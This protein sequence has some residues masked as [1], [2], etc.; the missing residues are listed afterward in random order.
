MLSRDE[1]LAIYRAG[2]E[3]MVALVEKLWATQVTLEQQVQVLAA[4]VAELEARL[5]Q[6]SHNSHQPPSSDGP[7]KR[8]RTRSLRQRSGKK[9]GGQA[10][11]PGVTRALVDDPDVVIPHMPTV[12]VGCGAA[13]ESVPEAGRERRQVIEIPKPRP[14]VTEHQAVQKAC[15]VC[16]TLTAGE[17]PPEVAQPVQ[18]GPRAKAAGVYLQTYQLLSYER[19]VEALGD[20]FGVYPSE[21]TLTSAQR[22][23]YARLE[24]V[25]QA[26][27]DA[28]QEADV[29]HVDETGIRVAGRTEWAHV[30]STHLLTF[31][32]HHAK[33]GREAFK[34]TGLLL[35]FGGRRVH[36]AWAP[37][38]KL[39][40]L[41]ALCNA[42]LLRELIGLHEETGHAW[43][44]K[45]IRLLLSMKA[46]VAQ[47]RAAGQTALTPRQRAGFE[48][49]YTH[50][51][52]EGLRANPPPKPTGKRGRP[53][54]TPARN[55]LDRL[56]THRVAILAFLHDFRVP[57]DNNQ[58]E[59]DLRMLKVKHKISGC[60]RSP[61]GAAYFC[62]IRG[63]LSTL[64][65]Q[66]YSILDGL[67][68]VFAGQPY[69]PRL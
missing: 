54:Q 53:K 7:A 52:T 23:A 66:D 4:R 59:R 48:A 31:Y 15:P 32:A 61:Q 57:F 13:L 24:P 64:R 17:F 26:I 1:I 16:Q 35:G 30:M 56:E 41:Y 68:S 8:P 50:F 44:Q 11:H 25:E 18:Y 33:R 12:C 27:R 55:L 47:A 5:N 65:K 28:L 46:A 29:A 3:A 58:A 51:V 62:R 60:F 45:L 21:G 34:A 49:A 39:P 40:G 69:M 10:G 6:D 14:E 9:S 63:Y 42:H 37:Y 19:T 67:T 38:L 43:V 20:L 2:P 36:D 22:T